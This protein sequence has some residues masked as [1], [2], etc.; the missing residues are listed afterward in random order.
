MQPNLK[1]IKLALFALLATVAVLLISS[2][3][4]KAF[5]PDE[6]LKNLVPDV[7]QGADTP[8]DNNELSEDIIISIQK[9]DIM[10]GAGDDDD[11]FDTSLPDGDDDDM[12]NFEGSFGGVYDDSDDEEDDSSSLSTDPVVTEPETSATTE[13]VTEPVTE[14]ET[15]PITEPIPEE[16]DAPEVSETEDPSVFDP[17]VT[18][19]DPYAGAGYEFYDVPL[20]EFKQMYVIDTAK[21]FGIPPELIFGVMYAESRYDETIIH[22][23]GKYIG[24]MQIAKSNLKMLTKKFGITDLEDFNQN[25]IAG[26]YFLSYFYE[27]YDGDIDKILMCYHCGEGGAKSLWKKGTTQDSYCRKVRAEIDR[28]LEAFEPADL[29]GKTQNG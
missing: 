19:D 10:I 25:V 21:E 28:I 3:A 1:F 17:T 4:A 26:A 7:G 27:K 11:S 13:A 5:S 14:S 20:P 29:S 23:S 12:S 8:I 15:D 18:E 2:C 22:S 24:I 6:T 9:P 16:T